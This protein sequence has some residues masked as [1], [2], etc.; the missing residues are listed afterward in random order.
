MVTTLAAELLCYEPSITVVL[1]KTPSGRADLVPYGS[2]HRHLGNSLPAAFSNDAEHGGADDASRRAA[3][4]VE[5]LREQLELESWEIAEIP[6]YVINSR[7]LAEHVLFCAIAS[8]ADIA[9][10]FGVALLAL[11]LLQWCR[12]LA[13]G[14]AL[15][16]TAV[17]IATAVGVIV[18]R[19]GF[20]LG[21]WRYGPQMPTLI[22]VGL[23][24]ILQLAILAPTAIF[25]A[26]QP[27]A[28]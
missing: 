13:S 20:D 21:I 4:I 14:I 24:P 22:G 6:F 9:M 28:K 16:L 5:P 27:L 23:L 11:R 1:V 10:T 7:Q 3:A 12:R 2:S 19:I 25:A 18:E 8:V 17:G 26:R 15:Y